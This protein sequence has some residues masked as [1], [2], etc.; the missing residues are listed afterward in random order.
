MNKINTTQTLSLAEATTLIERVGANCTM[1]LRGEPGIGKST[2]LKTLADR[3]PEY[4]AVYLD[5]TLLDLGD[6]QMPLVND[7]GV[8]FVP[9]KMFVSDKPLLLMVDELGKA[10]RPVQNALLPALNGEKRIGGYHFHKDSIVFATTNLTSDGVGDS[11]QAHAKNR[12]CDVIVGK[13]TADAWCAWGMD[14]GVDPS[15]LAWVGKNPQCMESYLDDAN[16]ENPYI[17]NPRKQQAAF[18]SPR[19]LERASNVLKQRAYLTPNALA[20]SLAGCVGSSAAVDMQAFVAVAD[21]LPDWSMIVANP[22]TARVPESAIAQRIL[23][24]TAVSRIE[25]NTADAW[26]DYLPRL[27][28]EVQALFAMSVMASRK[29]AKVVT[30]QKFTSFARQ[31]HWIF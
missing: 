2:I 24:L 23:A 30:N 9:N 19:S 26:M 29:A 12:M 4:H 28:A 25:S 22:T 20:V 21:E 6:L 14:N 8:Q 5:A 11:I 10:M 7:G 27:Q 3:M 1:L 18:V 31:N 15:L 13:P 16:G 17:F